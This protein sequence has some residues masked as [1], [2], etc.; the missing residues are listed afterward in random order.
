MMWFYGLQHHAT[1]K[2]ATE[3]TEFGI[4]SDIIWRSLWV[5]VL[6]EHTQSVLL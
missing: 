1:K 3:S 4:V 2:Y 6:A 5:G